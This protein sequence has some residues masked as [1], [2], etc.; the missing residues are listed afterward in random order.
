LP[1]TAAPI[2]R[3]ATCAH[4]EARFTTYPTLVSPDLEVGARLDDD[5]YMRLAL[6]EG[7]AAAEQGE[8]PVGAVLVCDGRVLAKAA[9]RTVA[10]QDATAHAE[11]LVMRAASAALGAWR[12]SD[13]TLYV[14]LE[15]CA[16]C[17]GAIVL[18][19]VQRVVFGAWDDKAGM[20]G[21]VED[22]L[23]HRRL[24][25]RPEVRAGVLAEECAA[26]LTSFFQ[27]RR[28]SVDSLP[29]GG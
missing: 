6:A 8:V 26:L 2:V 11:M 21:S 14:T 27:A 29:E 19:R 18:A 20:A 15:P 17:A 9:N 28:G 23:R 3:V 16:M 22:L 13:C 10:E 5:A 25:H 1:F 12:L 24:N 4:L 7:R